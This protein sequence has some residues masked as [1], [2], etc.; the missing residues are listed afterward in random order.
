MTKKRKISTK[1]PVNI[2]SEDRF[3]FNRRKFYRFPELKVKERKNVF[4][5]HGGILINNLFPVMRSL[6]NAFGFRKPNAGFIYQFYRKGIE[7]FLV[8]KYG[9]SL[10]S[11]KL[12]T[13]KKYLFVFSPWF[14]YFS[15]VTESLPRIYSVKNMH[16]ELTLILPETYSKKKFVMNSLEMFPN[17]KYEVIPEG[18]HMEIPKLTMPELKPFT[19]TFDPITMKDYRKKVWDHVDALDINIEVADRIY[20]SRKRAKN[21]MLVNDQDVLDVFFKYNFKEVC[22]EDYNF[23]EQVYLMKNCDVLA[24]VHGAGFANIAFMQEKSKLFELIK[25]Y[26]SYK[27][28]R[29][30]YWRLCSALDID[31]YIQYCK[32]ERYGKYDLWV[33][34]NLVVNIDYL[35]ENLNKLYGDDKKIV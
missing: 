35:N 22:F 27:E 5:T 34:V 28:E 6:P 9:K 18:V 31:Y 10:K 26:S 23:F 29:I 8:S 17:L 12:D 15:W 24:G 32:P 19:Y 4:L 3:I 20:V 11:V 1:L 13:E 25:E 7:I 2:R 16:E 30:S 21:R 14:G 33:G